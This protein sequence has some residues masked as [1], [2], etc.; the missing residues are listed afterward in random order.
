MLHI[1]NA[2]SPENTKLTPNIAMR[3]LPVVPLLRHLLFLVHSPAKAQLKSRT[4]PDDASISHASPPSYTSLGIFFILRYSA[5]SAAQL[6]LHW[7]RARGW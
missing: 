2:E 3:K 6:E 5:H 1:L 7:R 4:I